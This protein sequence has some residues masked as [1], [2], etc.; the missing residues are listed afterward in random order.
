MKMTLGFPFLKDSVSLAALV[1]GMGAKRP[2]SEK[3]LGGTPKA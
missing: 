3:L 2:S 1:V